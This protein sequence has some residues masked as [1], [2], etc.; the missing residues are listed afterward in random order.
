MFAG[1]KPLRFASLLFIPGS[2]AAQCATSPSQLPTQHFLQGFANPSQFP[3][4]L[5]FQT[6][7]V[8]S[9]PIIPGLPVYLR[10]IMSASCYRRLDCQDSL[11]SISIERDNASL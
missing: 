9:L 3:T 4:E 2:L 8:L 5:L 11:N 1:A 7:Y 6:I 10:T